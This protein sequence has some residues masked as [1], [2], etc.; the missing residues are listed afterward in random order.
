MADH[1]VGVDV[2]GG[3]FLVAYRPDR[4][5]QF[6]SPPRNPVDRDTALA[7]LTGQLQASFQDGDTVHVTF[8]S[9]ITRFES[10]PE[11]LRFIDSKLVV[12]KFAKVTINPS[13]QRQRKKP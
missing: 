9:N 1:E 10:L 4:S 5:T 7:F 8:G 3:R 6:R 2:T 13:R 12:R 11:A